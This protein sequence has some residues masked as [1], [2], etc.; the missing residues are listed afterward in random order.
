M[1][2]AAANGGSRDTDVI[3]VGSGVAGALVAAELAR[4]GARV[5]VLEAG[6]RVD[7][8][9]AVARFRGSW[10]QDLASPF[11]TPAHAP[12]P[13]GETPD[14]YLEQLG[15]VPYRAFYV[16]AVGGTTWHWTGITPRFLPQ[17]FELRS[18]YRVGRD[19]PF[20]Y[21][22]LEP[23][24]ARAEA[25]LGVSGDSNDDH[26][27]PRSTRYP[28]PALPMPYGDQVCRRRLAPH[29]VAVKVMPAARNS[30]AYAGRPACCGAGSCSP[31]CPVGA[32]YSADVHAA[33]AEKAGARLIT[34]AVVHALDVSADGSVR[35]VRWKDAGSGEHRVAARIVVLA[36]NGIETPRLMLM[37]RSERTPLG[38]GNATGQVGRYLMDHPTLVIGYRLTEPMYR[39]RGPQIVSTIDTHRDGP[40]REQRAAVK[41]NLSNALNPIGISV[42]ALESERNW[43]GIRHALRGAA[44]FG[45]E[46][47]AEFEQ[48]PDPANQVMLSATRK[49]PLGL[50]V[51]A[52]R[53]GYDAYTQ[54][55]LR[56]SGA[57]LKRVI[58]LMGGRIIEGHSIGHQGSQHLMGTTL[59]G[60]DPRVSV[61]NA[62]CRVHQHSNLYIAGSSVFPS[63][64]TANPTLTI[65]ALSLRLADRLKTVLAQQGV[66]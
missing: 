4:A 6:D 48:L 1:S 64:G 43:S 21:G 37:S 33:R 56:A 53:Y 29:G 41:Y 2:T 47:V 17:D 27:S 44:V 46:I 40:F 15:P 20:G 39:G 23:Y 5:T 50:P 63:S 24:Y 58:G 31:I 18:R 42:E 62:D 66:R 25:E 45:G 11:V 30:A 10:R 55:G 52:I 35:A 22:V 12:V 26:G 13:D 36:C 14:G 8:E 65:A 34:G 49:D 61:V 16:R 54:E 38:I 60:T 28:M 19:W 9:E 7:R 57:F 51:P 3:V 32:S 59:M